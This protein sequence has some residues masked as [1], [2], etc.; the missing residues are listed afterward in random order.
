MNNPSDTQITIS[1]DDLN[2]AGA[3]AAFG[4]D[5]VGALLGT[6]YIIAGM[7]AVIAIIIGGV[8]YVSSNGDSSQITAAKNT[9]MYAVIGLIVVIIAATITTFVIQNITQ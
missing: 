4:P 8:R 2:L 9:I 7:V 3:R 5:Q 1:Q 6:V